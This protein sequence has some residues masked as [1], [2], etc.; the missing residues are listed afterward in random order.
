MVEIR[1]GEHRDLERI[2]EFP[3][4]MAEETEGFKLDREVVIEG[5]RGVFEEPARG[6]YWVAEQDGEISGVCL[7]I[8]EWSDWRNGTV[9]WIHSLYVVPEARGRGIF[10]KL[11]EHL[12][13]QVEESEELVGLRLYV[14]KKNRLAQEV[15][16][17][18]GMSKDHYEL[19]EWLK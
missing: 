1:K 4:R 16:E 11:Y 2:V 8:P 19:Y 18:L 12:K 17:R 10:K 15:Y 14:D 6:T 3:V 7:A 13:E 9:L 5:V